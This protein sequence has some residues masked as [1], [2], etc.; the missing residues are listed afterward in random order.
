MSG[1]ERLDGRG[2]P[3]GYAFRPEWEVTPRE[4]KERMSL[5]EERRPML[6]DC[7]RDEEWGLCRIDG[8]VHLPM[9][10][11]E[12]RADELEDEE[13]KRDHPVI[14]YC[15]HGQ[16]SLRV[17]AALRAMG[18]ADVRS[19]AGGIDLWSADV[20]PGVARY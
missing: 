4:T 20:D 12:R 16:R 17:T 6:V 14:V 15:H 9:Q 13:G 19:M 5:P 7:R 3:A 8:A 18:F 1:G 11:I 2:L 10:E